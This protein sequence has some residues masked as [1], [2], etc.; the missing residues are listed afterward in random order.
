MRGGRAGAIPSAVSGTTAGAHD[1]YRFGLGR[2]SCTGWA[3]VGTDVAYRVDLAPGEM[4]V[5]RLQCTVDLALYLLADC[6][7][8]CCHA[9]VDSALAG[10]S[11]VLAYRNATA[12][13]QSLYLVVDSIMA[14]VAGEF[15]LALE[16]GVNI[17][18][19]GAS[20]AS[21]P[22]APDQQPDG[23]MADAGG[24]DRF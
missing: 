17:D 1:D 4:L 15:A 5:A 2:A 16:V 18:P 7:S 20:V 14:A 22:C 3:D 10:G 24:C 6:S 8:R 19:G 21:G 13:P 9:G 23:G 11:E 12:A